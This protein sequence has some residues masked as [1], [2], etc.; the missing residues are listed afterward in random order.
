VTTICSDKTGTLT[1]NRMQVAIVDVGGQEIDLAEPLRY[2]QPVVTQALRDAVSPRI[3]SLL[4]IG[5]LCND[6]VLQTQA[7]AGS[8]AV[9]DPTEGALLVAAAT[10]G[11]WK[12]ELDER[13]PRVAEAPFTSG[14]RR[15]TTIHLQQFSSLPLPPLAAVSGADPYLA[16]VKGSAEKLLGLSVSAL[17]DGVRPMTDADRERIRSAMDRLAWR[18]LRVLRVACRTVASVPTDVASVERGLTFLELVGLLDPPRPEVRAAVAG[19]REAGIRTVMNTGDHP[20]TALEIARQL[21]SLLRPLLR[22]R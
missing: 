2:G 22:G 1:E 10:H 20:L 8:V 6:A 17:D 13:L 14:R 7:D 16:A 19:C 11:L 12:A 15:M 3:S 21:S 9:G 18:G 5:A 4:A